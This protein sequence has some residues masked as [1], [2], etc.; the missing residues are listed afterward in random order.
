MKIFPLTPK[1]LSRAFQRLVIDR[2]ASAGLLPPWRRPAHHAVFAAFPPPPE[3]APGNIET[4]YLGTRTQPQMRP[5]RWTP[6]PWPM[7][8]PIPAFSEEYF[9]WI[10]LL[11][12]VQAAHGSFTMLELGA[13]YGRWSVRGALAARRR[14]LTVRLGAA[15]AEPQ[16]VIWLREHLAFNGISQSECDVIEA[17][18]SDRRGTTVFYVSMPD[19]YAGNTAQDWYGQAIVAGDIDTSAAPTAEI[20]FGRPLVPLPGGW[21]GVEVA[22]I[23]LAEVLDRYE[24][25]DFSDF[26]IQGEELSAIGSALDALG[27][28]VRRL[29]IGT[30]SREIDAGLKKLLDAEGWQCLRAHSCLRWNRTE[31][32]W[33]SFGDGVQSWI[34]PR[35]T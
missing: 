3:V 29:H 34:N 21:K 20:Y 14:G 35:L 19:G 31:F 5:K 9:E 24:F 18:I 2:A 4:D 23:P 33:I 26:D 25:V 12:A 30:H 1:R 27:R 28:K 32:G 11:E 16:H 7:S 8:L 17:A 6:P 10:D 13:G 15:E 22:T